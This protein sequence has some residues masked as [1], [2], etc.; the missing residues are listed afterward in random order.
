MKNEKHKY[1]RRILLLPL[2]VKDILASIQYGLRGIFPSEADLIRGKVVSNT[3][4]NKRSRS[5]L[6]KKE[7]KA[8]QQLKKDPSI[9]IT[10]ADKSNITIVLTKSCM[11]TRLIKCWMIKK[12]TNIV[13]P[14]Q[15]CPQPK[16]PIN[17]LTICSKPKQSQKKQALD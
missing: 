12:L 11:T 9:I 4:N 17:L 1:Q 14:T 5:V 7:H 3:R 8:L 2:I 10:K 13:K 16:M 6:T 15:L